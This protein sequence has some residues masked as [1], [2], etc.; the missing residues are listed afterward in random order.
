MQ[1]RLPVPRAVTKLPT[2]ERHD[3]ALRC[4]VRC[5]R[6]AGS[7]VVLR[8]VRAT[9]PRDVASRAPWPAS[10]RDGSRCLAHVAHLKSRPFFVELFPCLTALL[11]TLLLPR[12]R[13]ASRE[14]LPID[15]AFLALLCVHFGLGEMHEVTL[16]RRREGCLARRCLLGFSSTILLWPTSHFLVYSPLEPS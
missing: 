5:R 10:E 3:G 12:R 9:L 13:L 1:P 6:D 16:A 14:E 7:G 11:P 15:A 8:S 2:R 4:R